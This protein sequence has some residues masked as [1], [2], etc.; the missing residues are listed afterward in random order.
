MIQRIIREFRKYKIA[1]LFLLPTVLG[2]LTMHVGP[3]AQGIWMAFLDLNQFT[4]NQYLS[5][6]FIGFENFYNVL[7]NPDSPVRIGVFEAT[8]NTI[9]YAIIVTLGTLSLGMIVALMVNRQFFG[10]RLIRTLFLFPW[11]VPTYVTGILWGFM[12]QRGVGIIN[13]ILVDILHLMPDKP[14]WLIG[15]NTL[16]AIIIPTIWRYWPFSMLLLLAG[17]QSIPEE[18]YEAAD[19]D[20][21]SPW[22][23]FWSITFPL[24]TPVWAVLILFGMIYNVYSFNIVIMMF[25]FGAGFPGEWGDLLMTNIFRN[26]FM[27]WNFGA[28][29]AA[30][31]VLMLCMIFMVNIW[32]YFYR[33]AEKRL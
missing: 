3:I 1:Y 2:M 13:I 18:L 16:W 4:I 19:I 31:V 25:G 33:R 9:I 22:R 24:L 21:A 29:A 17:M 28:G 27:Q 23:K 30:S 26:S 11:V 8:R 12:W 20:G 10:K 7:L 15:P 14:F 6:P 5:A 32:F